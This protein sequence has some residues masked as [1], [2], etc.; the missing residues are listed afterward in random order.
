MTVRKLLVSGTG[1]LLL[2]PGFL[3]FNFPLA[4]QASN[5][6]YAGPLIGTWLDN[7]N[8]TSDVYKWTITADGK[9]VN[10]WKG[11]DAPYEEARYSIEKRW[12]DEDGN[13]IRAM[14]YYPLSLHRRKVL[15]SD[16]NNSARHRTDIL[17]PKKS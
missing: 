7:T 14:V 8:P 15:Y 3:V 2:L 10:Y 5:Q 9:A 16:L 17:V 6:N 11:N 4:A 1:F 12:T 13:T